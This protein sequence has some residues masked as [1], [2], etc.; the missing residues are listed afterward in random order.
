MSMYQY[1][2]FYENM[3]LIVIYHHWHVIGPVVI[4]APRGVAPAAAGVPNFS[5]LKVATL[6]EGRGMERVDK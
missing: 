4:V 6:D 1:E 2:Y 3:F 5:V